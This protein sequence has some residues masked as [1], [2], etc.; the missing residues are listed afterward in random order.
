MSGHSKWAGIKHK[1]AAI[2]AQKGKVFSKFA[3]EITVAVKQGGPSIETNA[4][5]RMVISSAKEVNMPSD[6]IKK[7]IMRGTG[8]LPG[9]IYEESTYEG[10]GPAGVAMMVTILTDNK[11]RAGAEVRNI[12]TKNGGNLGEGGC[13]A[14]MFSRKGLIT[15][16]KEGTD[17]DALIT[18]ALE[19]G[20]DD[21]KS[22]ESSFEVIT[23][24][25]NLEK[26]KEE[27]TKAGF[28]LSSAEV[29]MVPQNYIR[30]EEERTARQILNLMNALEDH[31]DVQNVYANFD[32]PDEIIEKVGEEIK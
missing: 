2:D 23:T 29:S 24:A 14:W 10:Y 15:L 25:E 31:D 9:V 5:L 11:N 22:D 28:K 26:V 27:L 7:A 21:V 4:R 32:I 13:V 20:A 6:N 19:A 17:E 16:E 12:F 1:K 8:E 30:V 3:K 18:T